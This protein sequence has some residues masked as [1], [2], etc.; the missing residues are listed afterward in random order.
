DLAQRRIASINFGAFNAGAFDKMLRNYAAV[1][2]FNSNSFTLKDIRE[3]TTLIIQVTPQSV[4]SS[5]TLSFIR[6]IQKSKEVIIAGFGNTTA[7]Q[8]LDAFTIPLIWNPH[9]TVAAVEQSAAIIFGGV[10]A[11]GRLNE[12]VSP[13]FSAGA[14]YTTS[15]IRLKYAIPEDLGISSVRLNKIDDVVNSAIAGHATPSAVVM[16]V[17]DGNVIFNKAY[18]SHTY[19]GNITT[20]TS[21]IYD[22]ASV[23]KIGATTIAAMKLYEEEKLDM[24]ADIGTYLSDAQNTNKSHIAVRDVMLHQAGFVNLDFLGNLRSS[25][26]TRDSSF[27]YPVK[28]GDNY[29]VRKDFYRD[30]MWP[31][32]LR[33][34]L[35]TRGQYVYSDISMFMMKEIIEHQS[36]APLDQ[37]V[38]N[39]FYKKLGMRTAGFNPRRRFDK[40]QI[41]PTERDN[42]FRKALL[43]GYVHDSG[44]ALVDGV[45]GHAGL[46]A[47][48]NDLA[49]LNQMLLNGGTYGGMQYFKPETVEMFTK[50]QSA[51]SR[52]GYGFD[53]GNGTSYPCRY[54]SADTYGHTGYTGTCVWVDP[55]EK[56]VYIF[57]SNRVYP[58]ATNKLN[59]LR[60]RPRVQDVI[61]EAIAESKRSM[62]ILVD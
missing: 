20:Q 14:G 53:R 49:I 46:F 23:T 29:Y 60:V 5:E 36:Q 4:F 21:D 39:N 27:F 41:V 2:S 45:S 51:V 59:S 24:D 6:E 57:L 56:L 42:Y 17:K 31:K 54:A 1:T 58:S 25:D 62:A 11:E 9:N 26:H 30:V 52:R 47:S 18:G 28:A 15:K 38:L 8:T 13:R 32:M 35:P 10:S 43:Q 3:Y 19:D 33:S 34:P 16:V 61:Y 12:S 7:L 22:V 55:K 40:D 48:A 37:F 50:K 44:A